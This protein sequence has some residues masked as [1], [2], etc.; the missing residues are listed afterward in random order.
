MTK[1]M[2]IQGLI[3]LVEGYNS[4]HDAILQEFGTGEVYQKVVPRLEKAV[5]EALKVYSINPSKLHELQNEFGSVEEAF[6]RL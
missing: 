4:V 6:R 2:P 1:P 5:D 3:K